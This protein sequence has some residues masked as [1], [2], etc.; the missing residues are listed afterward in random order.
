MA[1]N[2]QQEAYEKLLSAN[3]GRM[4]DFSKFAEARNAALLTF[5]SVWMGAII[6][7]LRSSDKLPL[8]YGY[9]FRIALLLLFIA[10]VISLNVNRRLNGTPY[11]RPKSTPPLGCNV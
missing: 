8:G 9:A 6:T 5:C 2:D 11:R 4:V 1:K 7:L 3:H 10:A